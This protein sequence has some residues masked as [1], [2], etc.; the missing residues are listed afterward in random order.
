MATQAERAYELFAA[1]VGKPEGAGQWLEVTQ[2]RVDAFAEVTEDRQW[3]HV[4]PVRAARESP[5]G[6]P[7]AH[8]FLTLSLLTHLANT[9]PQDPAR[10]E[11]VRLAVN[12]GFDKVR[13]VSPVTVG[14]RIRVS[15]VLASVDQK[16]PDTLQLV[17]SMTVEVDGERRPALVADWVTRLIY[18]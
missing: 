5:F 1:E 17:R 4:D 12:Y 2:E 7:I 11:T 10:L 13:F 3:I 15:S 18:G 14:S 8:G 6:A 9:L 16:D